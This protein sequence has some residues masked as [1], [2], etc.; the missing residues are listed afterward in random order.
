MTPTF[1]Y[2]P[3]KSGHRMGTSAARVTSMFFLLAV[4]NALSRGGL[5]QLSPNDIRI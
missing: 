4:T 5:P 2:T 3:R 1:N